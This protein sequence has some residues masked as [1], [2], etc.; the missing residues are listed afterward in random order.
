MTVKSLQ[1]ADSSIVGVWL[2]FKWLL[3]HR[4]ERGVGPITGE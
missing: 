4:P 1:G 3:E 2:D